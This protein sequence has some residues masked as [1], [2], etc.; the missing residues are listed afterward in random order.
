MSPFCLKSHFILAQLHQ[1]LTGKKDFS[2]L[3]KLEVQKI[4]FYFAVVLRI[5]I[6]IRCNDS[7]SKIYQ[8][9][10]FIKE[11]VVKIQNCNYLNFTFL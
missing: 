8:T 10:T 6:L 3:R 11:N 9:T 1:K 4:F 2:N 7:F 5:T